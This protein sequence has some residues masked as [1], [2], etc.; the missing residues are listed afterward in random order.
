[1]KKSLVGY[2]ISKRVLRRFTRTAVVG[3]SNIKRIVQTTM[4]PKEVGRDHATKI[5]ENKNV[6]ATPQKGSLQAKFN[7]ILK[8]STSY[9]KNNLISVTKTGVISVTCS[10]YPTDYGTNFQPPRSTSWES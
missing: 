3:L 6:H 2:K 9:R 4:P 5:W 7:N 8:I 1:M 10:R